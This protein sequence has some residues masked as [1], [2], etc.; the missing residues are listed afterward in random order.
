[1]VKLLGVSAAALIAGWA[2]Y[3]LAQAE[4][5]YGNDPA[6][7]GQL[8]LGAPQTGT[9]ETAGDTDWFAVNVEQ[10]LQY[11]IDL[12]GE[13]TGQGSL[14]DPL[15]Q[16]F[17]ADGEQIDRDDDGGSGLNSRLRFIADVTGVVYVAAG[18][19]G[20][21]TGTYTVTIQAYIPPPD[22]Y[23]GDT[24]TGAAIGVGEAVSGDV[25]H[26]GDQDWFALDL[27]A[28]QTY[29]IDLEG[30]ATGGGTLS[31]PYLE[32]FDSDG[33]A[34]DFDDDSGDGLN[35][36]LIVTPELDGRYYVGA[37]AFGAATGSYTL[38]LAEYVAPPDDYGADIDA[39]GS[40][41]VGGSTT[42]DIEVPDDVDWFALDLVAG[43]LVVIDLEGS[44]TGAGTLSDPVLTVCDAS[45][46]SISG[47]DDGGTDTNARLLFEPPSDGRY[48]LEAGGYGTA[49]GTYTLTVSDG[50]DIRDDYA[51][52]LSTAGRLVAGE[53]IVG[54]LEVA[55]DADWFA[56][57]LEAG[58]DYTFLLEGMPTDAGTL[59]DPFLALFDDRGEMMAS[60]DDDGHSLNS[61]IE[62]T[63]DNAGT[64]FL[65][66]AG[67]ADAI[68]SYTL[69]AEG[70]DPSRY[71]RVGD[72][73][74]GRV[75]DGDN[76]AIV[77]E[78]VD[79]EQ[80]TILVPRAYL[81]EI[82]S[83]YIGPQ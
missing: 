70:D 9:I 48:Y 66:A 39:A 64:F 3:A 75:Q 56:I 20:G 32:L 44:P 77:V 8:V 68:G 73:D 61:L 82:G 18:G 69:T 43:G 6:G 58:V 52:D 67:F 26:E 19:Y 45:G 27:T 29:A 50:G 57:Q 16:L 40:I 35:S 30:A 13:P 4:D 81:S 41:F 36:R 54:E 5:D 83:V 37:A 24:S 10:G 71:V 17:G 51:G 14:Q 15:V 72:V 79:G 53:Q 74:A 11:Q 28:G 80:L 22:D 63:P 21:D 59:S 1:M 78:L 49:I 65:E 42:G 23:A 46:A 55:G 47:D 25:G 12:E 60:N 62:F 76:I 38:S 34:I 33:Q 7:S 31:D 2:G